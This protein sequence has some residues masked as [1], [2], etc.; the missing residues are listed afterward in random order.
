MNF[1]DIIKRSF[2]ENFSSTDVKTTDVIFTLGITVFIAIYIFCVYRILTRKS[3]YNK[4]FN[5]GLPVIAVITAAIILTIQSSI[6]VSLG[7]VGA[8]SIVRFRTAIKDPLDL[9]FMFWAIAVGIMCGAGLQEIALVSSAIVTV[10]IWG[11]SL[12]PVAKTPLILVVQSVY[13]DAQQEK[14]LEVIGKYTKYYKVKSKNISKGQLNMIVELRIKEDG[15]LLKEV[16]QLKGIEYVSLI[17]HEGE[18][19]F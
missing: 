6:V 17:D 8:L 14:I 3:F 16:N 2:I 1:D 19:T 7:M 18:T 13:E 15:N 11:L 10:L 9:V 5:I 4:N 12:I